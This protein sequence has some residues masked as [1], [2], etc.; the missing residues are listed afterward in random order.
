ML[1]VQRL[2][3]ASPPSPSPPWSRVELPRVDAS[4]PPLRVALPDGGQAT[5]PGLVW[6]E[7]AYLSAR[8]G[9]EDAV[10]VREITRPQANALLERF[11]HPLGAYTRRF[12]EQHFALVCRGE[13]VAVACSGTAR[14]PTVAG[15]IA[16]DRVVELARIAR[17]PDHPRSL[18]ALLRLWTDYLAPLFAVKYPRWRV[19]FAISYALPTSADGRRQGNLYRFDGWRDLGLTRPWGGSTG[20]GNRSVANEIGDGRKRVFLYGYQDGEDR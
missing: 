9:F 15:G 8:P 13:A 19:D 4:P 7:A 20:W 11:A 17:H 5:L 14:R 18:R 10:A 1:T 12:G 16:R 2:A 6:P 3:E